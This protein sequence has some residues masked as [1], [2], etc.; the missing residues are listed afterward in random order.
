MATLVLCQDSPDAPTLRKQHLQAHLD[1]IE[2]I[3]EQV[4]VAGPLSQSD[5]ALSSNT[6]DGSCFLY[7]TDD[8][9]EARE[10]FAND[11]YAIAGV[12]QSVTFSKLKP[13]AGQWIG[14]VTW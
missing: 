4:S 10:L 6:F 2:E 13:A 5:A 9:S 1:Y 11:P 14:G 8:I 7:A 12:Y 3:I